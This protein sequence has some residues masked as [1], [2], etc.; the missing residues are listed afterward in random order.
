MKGLSALN[1]HCMGKGGG[2]GGGGGG[3]GRDGEIFKKGQV[4]HDF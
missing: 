1:Q 2:V 4:Y 3:G